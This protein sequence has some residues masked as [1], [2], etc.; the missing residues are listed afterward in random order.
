VAEPRLDLE[1]PG[2]PPRRNGELAFEA[3]WESRLFGVTL[4]LC[5][6]GRFE[7]EEFR[8]LLIEEI[9]RDDAAGAPGGYRYYAHWQAAFERLLAAKGLCAGAELEARVRALAERPAGH[10]HRHDE[11]HDH[12]HE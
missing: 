3:P 7:W 4:A 10:D 2:A 12:D 5:E 6:A 1:G 9:A 11:H 8:R